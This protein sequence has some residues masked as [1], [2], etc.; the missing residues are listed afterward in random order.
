MSVLYEVTENEHL[1]FQVFEVRKENV[2]NMLPSIIFGHKK[3]HPSQSM[4]IP[5]DK[6]SSL[7]PVNFYGFDY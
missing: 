1:C 4:G 5:C 6:G 7:S 2:E 3:L